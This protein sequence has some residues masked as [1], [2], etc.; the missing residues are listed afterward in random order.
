VNLDLKSHDFQGAFLHVVQVH[1][2]IAKVV[3]NAII[4]DITRSASTYAATKHPS[5][6]GC[7]I[8]GTLTICHGAKRE[9]LGHLVLLIEGSIRK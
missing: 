4:I 7:G 1:D 6:H 9:H 5:W 8:L 2:G 3:L